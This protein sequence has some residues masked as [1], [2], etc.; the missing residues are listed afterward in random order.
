V[1][2]RSV[3]EIPWFGLIKLIL[4][5]NKEWPSNSMRT[6]IIAF[7]VIVSLPFVVEFAFKGISSLIRKDGEVEEAP[8][9]RPGAVGE[10]RKAPPP[11]FGIRSRK[12][13]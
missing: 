1:I 7:I 3:G 5:G 6:L 13:R 2:G 4:E 12:D 9:A 10:R 8:P 11:P